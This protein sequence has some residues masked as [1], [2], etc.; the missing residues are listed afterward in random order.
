MVAVSQDYRQRQLS[1]AKRM[2]YLELNTNP[3]Y[4]DQYTGALFLP[5]TDINKFPSVA[6]ARARAKK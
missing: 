5:H 3:S 4:M 1:L 2:T 6:D